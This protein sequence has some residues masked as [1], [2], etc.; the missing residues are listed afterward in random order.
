MLQEQ[1]KDSSRHSKAYLP[2]GDYG[3]IGNLYTVAFW[4]E[5]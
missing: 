3:L 5:R 1:T 4:I 2:I